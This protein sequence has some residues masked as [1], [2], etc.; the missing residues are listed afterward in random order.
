MG[1]AVDLIAVLIGLIW[2]LKRPSVYSC[3]FVLLYQILVLGVNVVLF[4]E[5]SK[6]SQAAAVM[7]VALRAVGSGL[8]IY[9]IVQTRREQK[10]KLE[11]NHVQ[12]AIA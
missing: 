6:A 10:V 5:N 3:S 1:F 4:N 2:C 9:A 8:A 7:H 11:L 12:K